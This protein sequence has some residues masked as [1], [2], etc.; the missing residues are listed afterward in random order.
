METLLKSTTLHHKE[1]KRTVLTI[2]EDGYYALCITAST[3]TAWQE[4]NNESLML[5]VMIDDVHD[6][7]II[8]F[9]GNEYFTY[10]RL[11]GYM[12][13]GLYNLEI[14]CDSSR[15]LDAFADIS[16]ISVEKLDLTDRET[17]AVS[18]AP[19]LFGRAVYS[20]YD[21]LYT[22][23]PL[24]MIYFFDKWIGGMVIEY[25]MVF[26][27]EDE[28]TPARLLMSKWGRLLDIEYMARVYLN[29]HHDVVHVEYQGPHHEVLTYRHSIPEK[30]PIVLQTATCNGN[31]TDD[32]TSTYFFRFLP[33]YEW[34]VDEEPREVVMEQFPYI[35]DVMRWEA[36]RQ[37]HSAEEPYNIIEDVRQYVYV[38]SSVWDV[39]LGQPTVDVLCKIQGDETWYSSSL[40]GQNFGSFSAAYTGPYN[41]FSTAIRLPQ[42]KTIHDLEEIKV[43]LINEA[44]PHVTVKNMKLLAYDKYDDL[45]VY[46]SES[47]TLKLNQSQPE[48]TVWRKRMIMGDGGNDSDE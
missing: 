18:Y 2:E 20:E 46:S 1:F 31:F 4:P 8:L 39:E 15:S 44:L 45:R 41:H 37:L 9:Y 36:E 11:L 6:Q 48:V 22:D 29:E 19:I 5:R 40:E 34:N 26:S 47:F 10:K 25:Q 32:I 3:S 17:L 14:L 7:D 33:S 21:N 13:A 35:N 42:E 38:Q 16:R 12:N 28:G 30:G 24:E 23:T 27:H 43:R